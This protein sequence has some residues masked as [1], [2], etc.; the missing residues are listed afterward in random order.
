[1]NKRLAQSIAVLF[2][3]SVVFSVLNLFWTSHEVT[4]QEQ[5]QQRAGQVVEAKLCATLQGL[6]ALKPPA[7]SPGIN[8]SRA[9]D[10]RLH[11]ELSQLGPDVGC[12]KPAR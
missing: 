11:A 8:P 7:G 3:L 10:Q 5:A 12:R 1:M 6:A 2:V 4:S 9:Y